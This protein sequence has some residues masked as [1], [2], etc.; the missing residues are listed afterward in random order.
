MD[1]AE[2][3]EIAR[4]FHEASKQRKELEDKISILRNSLENVIQ[5]TAKLSTTL[6]TSVGKNRQKKDLSYYTE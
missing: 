6:Q 3:K 4:Q 1:N 2:F 5:H